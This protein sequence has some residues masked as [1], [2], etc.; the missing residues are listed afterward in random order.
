MNVDYSDAKFW[1][2]FGLIIALPLFGTLAV[3]AQLK[4]MFARAQQQ[5]AQALK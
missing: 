4:E 1:L 3:P 5:N 2:W